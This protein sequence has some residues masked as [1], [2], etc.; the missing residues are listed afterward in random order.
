MLS[1]AGCLDLGGGP[2]FSL[3]DRFPSSEGALALVRRDEDGA[4]VRARFDAAGGAILEP[5]FTAPP[6]T[7]A[8]LELVLAAALGGPLVRRG[9]TLSS[10]PRSASHLFATD[11][12]GRVLRLELEASGATRS[13]EL[14]LGFDAVLP[15]RWT[16]ARS[17]GALVLATPGGGEL[18]YEL[19]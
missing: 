16:V 6:W 5:G 13:L 19:R 8:E 17:A 10:D 2:D 12:E 4:V 9:V 18:R 11:A 1:L 14:V 7:T 3:Q 15:R